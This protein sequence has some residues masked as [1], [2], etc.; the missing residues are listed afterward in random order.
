MADVAKYMNTYNSS[1]LWPIALALCC[2]SLIA[3]AIIF[4]FV[5]RS[6]NSVDQVLSW[7]ERAAQRLAEMFQA[8]VDISGDSF[9]LDDKNIAELA[10]LQRR[11][12]CHTRYD[13]SWGGSKAVV[14][15]RGVYTIKTGYDLNKPFTI[16]FDEYKGLVNADFSSPEILS[17]TTD[18][19]EN[20]YVDEGLVKRLTPE[21]M[22]Q[23][24]RENLERARKESEEIGLLKD[25]E[26]QM[27]QRMNDLLGAF[28]KQVVVSEPEKPKG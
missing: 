11:V 6:F 10:I 22:M 3:G 5:Y 1:K 18:S 7:P 14:I 19:I 8:K 4:Y 15:V 16:T 25:T 2:I 26:R 28:A 20:Y 13:T 23:A 12:V 27:M 21:D 9:T 24:Y 17:I